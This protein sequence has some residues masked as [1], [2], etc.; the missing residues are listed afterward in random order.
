ME[1]SVDAG[2]ET[3]GRDDLSVVDNA[4]AHYT[5]FWRNVRQLVDAAGSRCRR[6]SVEKAGFRENESAIAHRHHIFRIL[7]ALTDKREYLLV[8]PRVADSPARN[9][10]DVRRRRMCEVVVGTNVQPKDRVDRIGRRGNGEDL[11]AG[12]TKDF[13]EPRE[14]GSWGELPQLAYLNQDAGLVTVGIGGNDAHFADVMATCIGGWELLPFNTCHNDSDVAP[15]VAA[16]FARLDGQTDTPADIVPYDTLMKDVRAASPFAEHVMV[17]YPP[18]FPAEGGDRTF[19]PGGR[20]EG[21]KKADQRWMVETG[22]ELNDIIFRNAANNGFLFVDPSP[23]FSGHE[24]CSGGDEWFYGLHSGRHLG[25][26]RSDGL[27]IRSLSVPS[28][29]IRNE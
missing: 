7:R 12:V 2:R 15:V 27:P 29:T 19:L 23:A 26:C 25:V 4:F 5:R 10:E 1:R 11:R 6:E 28:F 17:G 14:G 16:S 13:Y 18:L 24:L 22:A 9:Q 8:F 21:V 3:G 20:C